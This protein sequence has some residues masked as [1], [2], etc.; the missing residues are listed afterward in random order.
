MR[1][2]R[3][4]VSGTIL[5]DVFTTGFESHVKCL[6][7]LPE[8]TKFAYSL[9]DS[10]YGISIVVEH[11]S[12]PEVEDGGMIPLYNKDIKLENLNGPR[13]SKDTVD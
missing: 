12:F 6:D 11:E 5:T 2:V 3:V 10:Y 8:G 13:T 1:Y 4:Q 7:G 9:P